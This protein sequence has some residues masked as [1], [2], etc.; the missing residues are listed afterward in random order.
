MWFP[1]LNGRDDMQLAIAFRLLA[2]ACFI[3]SFHPASAQ[4]F[5]LPIQCTGPAC[6]NPPGQLAYQDMTVIRRDDGTYFRYSKGNTTGAGLNVA[7]A[8]SLRGPWEYA[9]DVLSGPLKSPV[10]ADYNNTW[11][12]APEIR[13]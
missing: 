13:M 3:L 12:W 2:T 7:T 4:T 6:F 8:P 5:P 1:C 9:F 11:R 10:G